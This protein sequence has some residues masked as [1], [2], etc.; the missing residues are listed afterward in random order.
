MSRRTREATVKKLWK[1]TNRHYGQTCFAG[2]P[3][4]QPRPDKYANYAH[5]G[6]G[7]LKFMTDVE[8]MLRNPF[9]RLMR[10]RLD[11]DTIESIR[12]TFVSNIQTSL[13]L[14]MSW[15]VTLMRLHK[16]ICKQ[17][18]QRTNQFVGTFV[19]NC[20]VPD[21]DGNIDWD[22]IILMLSPLSK[23]TDLLKLR[24]TLYVYGRSIPPETREML[25]GRWT[26][27]HG[28]KKSRTPGWKPCYATLA[29]NQ[30]FNAITRITAFSTHSRAY[31]LFK[32]NLDFIKLHQTDRLRARL[33]QLPESERECPA[34]ETI[35]QIVQTTVKS[36]YQ[37]DIIVCEY[38]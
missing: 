33:I 27:P 9:E 36:L 2:R 20:F 11:Q 30:Y 37:L 8:T 19:Q 18:R 4:P 22:T 38:F 7:S 24:F 10:S 21:A 35:Q 13:Q 5:I 15:G 28:Q 29:K 3:K 6:A 17:I 16:H 1:F 32:N 25:L 14:R 31:S 12:N 34:G 23:E 26:Q